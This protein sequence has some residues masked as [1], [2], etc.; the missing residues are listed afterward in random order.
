ME[1]S[2]SQRRLYKATYAPIRAKE[3]VIGRPGKAMAKTAYVGALAVRPS[4]LPELRR[5]LSRDESGEL[6]EA[7]GII[8]NTVRDT[9]A[10]ATY[11]YSTE[12][13][14]VSVEALVRIGQALAEIREM[15]ASSLA[16]TISDLREQYR[17]WVSQGPQRVAQQVAQVDIAVSPPA[18]TSSSEAVSA[19]G[20]DVSGKPT[21]MTQQR[22]VGKTS[23]QLFVYAEQIQQEMGNLTSAE[24]SIRPPV[25]SIEDAI[26]WAAEHQ[27]AVYA[28]LKQHS[29]EHASAPLAYSNS[30]P[31]LVIAHVIPKLT[32]ASS[33]TR[34]AVSSF[35]AQSA[36]EPV[37][38]LHLERLEMT[39][40]GI[41]RGELVSSIPLTPKETVNITHREWSV[42]SREFE[43]IVQDYFEDYSEEGVT[44]KTDIAQST[45]NQ[46]KHASALSFGAAATASY[47]GVTLSSTFGYD[48]S[49]SDD[50]AQKDSR[51]HSI[52]TTRKSS[53]RVRKDHKTSF[54][55]SSASG[56]EDQAVRIITNP[57]ETEAMRVDYYQIM[58][59]WRVD[60]YR[61]GLRMTYDIV[62]PSPG[63]D[64]MRKF[65]DLANID[66]QMSKPFEFQL[67]V[68]DVTRYNW[69]QLSATY[70]VAVDAPPIATKSLMASASVQ[71]TAADKE[72][73]FVNSIEL[74]IE[75]NY[76]LSSGYVWVN[77]FHFDV[78]DDD[79]D[80]VFE[81][82]FDGTS[83]VK[84]QLFDDYYSSAMQNI[85]L[86]RSGRL[87]IPYLHKGV[88][89]ASI[90][91]T[92]T[93][94][95]RDELYQDWQSKAWR[96]LRSGAEA[97][98]QQ[99]WESLRERR[100]SLISDLAPFDALTL[101]RMELEEIMKGTMRWLFGPS[102]NVTPSD[103]QSIIQKMASNDPLNNDALDPSSLTNQQWKRMME[104]GEFIK[105]VHEAIEWENVLYF[106]YPYFWDTP[107]NW[108][109]KQLLEHPDSLHRTFL[110]AG[111][112]R[113]VLTIRPG[114]ERS[115]SELV[116]S[117]SFGQLPGDHPYITIAEEIQ[118]YAKTNY[119]GIPPANP[120]H[121]PKEEEVNKA[122]RGKLCATW[123]EYTPT[124]ALDVSINTPLTD[125]A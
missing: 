121:P 67:K 52:S 107:Q 47:L 85:L 2:N 113:V 63:A 28:V 104:F 97:I 82:L 42:S 14:S 26:A 96:A 21:R 115:F 110:R 13:A 30:D 58:R 33:Y 119:P 90:N 86:G 125:M 54:R 87:T 36:I 49:S 24:V 51:N 23:S 75:A 53:A 81:V 4:E 89:A 112:A 109:V 93:V 80:L 60:L 71:K 105:Y 56:T 55:V 1:L 76:V 94:T 61:Y 17:N 72:K 48:A 27:P 3:I 15:K 6:K 45:E 79:F 103:I 64:L 7:L 101:R 62:I 78:G 77:Y 41:E 11:R 83:M 116:E 118:K 111:S 65:K 117:G 59:K 57:S 120:A 84:N 44:D 20:R 32:E 91:V 31:T 25:E 114:F 92:Y 106:T 10:N 35:Q 46:T 99:N 38:R 100:A 22:T 9:S 18:P 108:T 40:V 124:S 34:A 74:D 19:E 70:Q 5:H 66:E 68:S 16:I 73:L 88:S 95:L 123:W 50:Q 37:G 39:P 102:F 12:L 122:E 98:H 8:E 43:S 29:M 69:Q